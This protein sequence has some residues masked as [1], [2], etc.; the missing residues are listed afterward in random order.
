MGNVGGGGGV[1]GVGNVGGVGSVGGPGMQG[2][3]QNRGGPM[4]GGPPQRPPFNH[5][6]AARQQNLAKIQQLQQTLE[7]AQQQEMQ[8]KSQLE[9]SDSEKNYFISF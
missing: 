6:E 1:G 5:I 9:V 4:L 2:P 8:Y 7:A 3:N